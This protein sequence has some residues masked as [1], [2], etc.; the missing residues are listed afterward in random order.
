MNLICM[1]SIFRNFDDK[2]KFF[3][4]EIVFSPNMIGSSAEPGKISPDWINSISHYHFSPN[5]CLPF[6]SNLR[7][8]ELKVWKI[9]F[10]FPLGFTWKFLFCFSTFPKVIHY[11]RIRFGFSLLQKN[12]ASVLIVQMYSISDLS[13]MEHLQPIIVGGIPVSFHVRDLRCFF[14]KF[15][16]EENFVFFHYRHR[17]DCFDN[18]ACWCPI[19]MNK[20]KVDGFL[21]CFSE[22]N[23]VNSVGDIL[24]QRCQIIENVDDF[25]LRRNFAGGNCF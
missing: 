21:N 17:I 14:S 2:L 12:D 19:L 10:Q 8:W 6:L 20:R 24:S 22:M 9:V 3:Q 13:L 1:I 18:S 7:W 5:S 15:V 11:F 23:W 4:K 25:L 16:E